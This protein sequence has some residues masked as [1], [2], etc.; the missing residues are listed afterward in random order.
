MKNVQNKENKDTQFN[1]TIINE[2]G[3]K[4]EKDINKAIYWYEKSAEQGTKD[5]QDYLARVCKTEDDIDK[6]IY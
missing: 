4:L 1:L 5:A 2:I 3:M 6:E